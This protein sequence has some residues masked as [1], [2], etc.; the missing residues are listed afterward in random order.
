MAKQ[1]QRAEI[2]T[3]VQGLITEASPL[4]FPPNASK[5]E[6]N[7]E[8]F[9]D[10]TRRRRLGMDYLPSETLHAITTF[11]LGTPLAPQLGT[12][13]WES[14]DGLQGRNIQV[15]QH[16]NKLDFYDATTIPYTFI[17]S[18]QVAPDDD[19]NTP[20]SFANIEG[21]LSVAWG[22]DDPTTAPFGYHPLLV[23]DKGT[24]SPRFS[25]ESPPLKVRDFWGVD[26]G[27]ANLENDPYFRPTN[28]P[29]LPGQI[30]NSSNQS[31]GI[32]RKDAAGVLKNPLDIYFTLDSHYPSNS[33][34]VWTGL[35]FQPVD[36]PNPPF[37]R[38]YANLYQEVFGIQPLAP[39]GF[40]TIDV[41]GRGN[42]RLAEYNRNRTVTGNLLY[43]MTPYTS[44]FLNTDITRGG[45]TVVAG[46]AG[47]A[48]YAGFPGRVISPDS[49]SPRL[50]SH[51]L[52]SQVIKNSKDM[53]KCY[54]DGDPTSRE[55]FD[56]VDT[57]GGFIKIAEMDQVLSLQPIGNTLVVIANNGIWAITGGNEFGFTASNY[58]VSQLSTFGCVSQGSVVLQGQSI[59]YWG[60]GGIYVVTTD[61]VSGAL[62]VN[63]ISKTTI[64][65]LYDDIPKTSLPSVKGVYDENTKKLR[66]IYK[67]GTKFTSTSVT[68]ELV[69]D[70]DLGNFSLNVIKNAPDNS[71][72]IIQPY[73]ANGEVNYLVHKNTVD[74]N[75]R[76]TFAK[77]RDAD[78]LD[79]KTND[80]I[81]VDAKAFVLTGAQIA[82]DSAVFKQAPY[83]VIHMERTETMTD[84]GGIPLNQ[85][86]CLFRTNWDWADGVQ[87]NKVGQLQQ[88]YR[89]RLPFNPGP[90][91][92]MDN[93]FEIISSRNKIRGRGRAIALYMETEPGKD[94]HIL[95]WNITLNGNPTA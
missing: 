37:E 57:D 43:D 59:M 11:G 44:F 92:S 69:F 89:Y 71:I 30:Y 2:N 32:P 18:Y 93:G 39:K 25:V 15:V 19:N 46:Y 3:F 76:Y 94:C 50:N 23:T 42:S 21:R 17:E 86:S 14:T 66:W 36:S 27:V 28:T 78:F 70:F 95:G 61:K 13:F 41:L 90:N 80:G 79:W 7:F 62:V 55:S 68:K 4:N 60:D 24:G 49:R 16:G 91:A 54:Q 12:F 45:P 51:I 82:G 87:S 34:V 22:F 26:T 52:F 84:S 58:K 38:V 88:A 6:E 77:Y 9:R 5:Q 33:E 74:L 65:T 56:I 85:S 48:W 40:F 20:Y 35:Q 67:E 47:R 81:G 1:G 83:I 8:L 53:V 31:W 73:F 75:G 10:G 64:Q 29:T 72:E 63:N